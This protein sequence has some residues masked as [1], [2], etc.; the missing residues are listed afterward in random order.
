MSWAKQI[1][2]KVLQIRDIEFNQG[3]LNYLMGR[4]WTDI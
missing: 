3:F 2:M 4:I 1:G